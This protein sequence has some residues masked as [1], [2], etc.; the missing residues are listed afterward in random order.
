MLEKISRFLNVAKGTVLIEYALIAG[1][2]VVAII[3]I[4]QYGQGLVDSLLEKA[5]ELQN[6]IANFITHKDS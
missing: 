1:I 2:V 4:V 5:N 6:E 3:G